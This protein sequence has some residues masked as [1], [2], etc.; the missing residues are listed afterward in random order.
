MLF[1]SDKNLTTRGV[2]AKLPSVQWKTKFNDVGTFEIHIS[3]NSEN[4]SEIKTYGFVSYKEHDGI[5]MQRSSTDKDITITGFDLNKLLEYRTVY[6][7][8]S[9]ALETVIK[10]YVREAFCTPGDRQITNFVVS[11]DRGRGSVVN[12]TCEKLTLAL[13][14]VKSLCSLD[15]FGFSITLIDNNFV[16]D[17]IEPTDRTNEIIFSRD[18]KNIT[19]DSYT[20]NVSK[21]KNV[22]RYTLENTETVDG[23]EIKTISVEEYNPNNKTGLDRREGV[24]ENNSTTDKA[25]SYILNNSKEEFISTSANQKAIYRHDYS[26]GDYVT[27][28]VQAFGEKI[29]FTKQITEV[30]EIWEKDKNKVEPTFGNKTI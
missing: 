24:A 27:V 19:E 12:W 15:G 8:K 5:I 29:T 28:C 13:D 18:Y 30:K 1:V 20:E 3:P 11:P 7:N 16:F 23:Q 10:E 2:F 6:G 17:L 21:E 25:A 9:G 22:A 26:V 4:L 14:T